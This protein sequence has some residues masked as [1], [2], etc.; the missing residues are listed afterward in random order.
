MPEAAEGGP[1]AVPRT[2]RLERPAKRND[3]AL[4]GSGAMDM[5]APPAGHVVKGIEQGPGPHGISPRSIRVPAAVVAGTGFGPAVSLT[6]RPSETPRGGESPSEAVA[7]TGAG[8]TENMKL[9]AARAQSV[10]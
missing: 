8:A 4:G 2:E 9:S 5:Q 7:A 10:R 3:M 1:L 6:D